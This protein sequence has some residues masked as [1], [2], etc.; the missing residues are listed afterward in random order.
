M[1]NLKSKPRSVNSKVH[2][3]PITTYCLS[4]YSIILLSKY[5]KFILIK[6]KL[7]FYVLNCQI[8]WDCKTKLNRIVLYMFLNS[9]QQDS[10]NVKVAARQSSLKNTYLSEHNKKTKIAW[11]CKICKLITKIFYLICILLQSSININK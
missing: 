10:E 1:E 5:Q 3:L 7:L 6:E 9:L 2:A 11:S 8:Q 4:G